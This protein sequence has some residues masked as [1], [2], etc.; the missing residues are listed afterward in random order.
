M[1]TDETPGGTARSERSLSGI[2]VSPGIAIGPAHIGER[3]EL[4]V[5]HRTIAEE[6]VEGERRR[7][8]EAVAASVQQLRRLKV[9]AASLPG[10]AA[11]EIGFLL[12]A[13][14]AMLAN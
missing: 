2:G 5:D 14:L 3:G 1:R 8:A 10:S 4:P 11:E 7:F 6:E 13:H 9:R 12:D